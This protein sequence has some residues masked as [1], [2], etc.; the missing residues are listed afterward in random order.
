MNRPIIDRSELFPD[1]FFMQRHHPEVMLNTHTHSHVEI[2]LPIGCELTYETKAGDA[3][4]PD[5]HISVLWAQI[6]HK[7]NHINGDGEIIIANL[8]MAELLSWGMPDSFLARLFAG[9][10]ITANK[11]LWFDDALFA[12]WYLDFYGEDERLRQISLTELQARLKRQSLIGWQQATGDPKG[13]ENTSKAPHHRL[14]NM[15]KYIADNYTQPIDVEDIAQAG[16]ICKGYAM[17]LFNVYL[18][19]TITNYLA[20]LRIHHAKTALTETSNKVLNIAFDAGFS[21][22]SRFYE[23]FGQHTGMSPRQYRIAQ[24]S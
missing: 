14:Q 2:L 20:Q 6:K 13:Q 23:V 10:L 18:D 15:I 3:I 24:R 17:G 5:G 22:L 11:T 16:G 12:N 1:S 9:E 7:L 19:T 8:P 21:S 4:A